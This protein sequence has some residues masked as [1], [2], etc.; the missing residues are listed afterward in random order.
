MNID[1]EKFN[2]FPGIRPFNPEESDFFFGR[3]NETEEITGKLLKNRFLAVIG[4]S[5][6]GKSSLINCGILSKISSI[7]S[8]D[9][10][11]DWRVF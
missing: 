4:V 11:S 5:G 2:P 9:F 3:D 1:A 7:R 10:S 8:D 6:E